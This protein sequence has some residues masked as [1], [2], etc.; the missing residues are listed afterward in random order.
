M[1]FFSSSSKGTHKSHDIDSRIDAIHMTSN[2]L[3]SIPIRG[4]SFDFTHFPE[5][6]PTSRSLY[7][8][9]ELPIAIVVVKDIVCLAFIL[10]SEMLISDVTRIK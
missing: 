5:L 8:G 10:F 3:V 1:S 2:E 7:L 9:F 4:G 6:T